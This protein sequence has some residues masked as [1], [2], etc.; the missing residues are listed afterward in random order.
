MKHEERL[1]THFMSLVTIHISITLFALTPQNGQTHSNNSL[2]TADELL[3]CVW[4][5]C[6]VGV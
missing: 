4:P 5:F 6:G 2:P 3:E 1:L